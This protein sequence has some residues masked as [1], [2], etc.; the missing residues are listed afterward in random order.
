M[1]PVARC[2]T[3]G[4]PFASPLF[5]FSPLYMEIRVPALQQENSGIVHGRAFMQCLAQQVLEK[6][7]Y[8]S[9]PWASS[10]LPVSLV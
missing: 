8:L 1:L 4:L 2:T 5:R 10:V 6:E 3:L 9:C 7:Y